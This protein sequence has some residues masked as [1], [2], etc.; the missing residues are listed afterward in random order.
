ME[1]QTSC[2]FL[3][4]GGFFTFFFSGTKNL[5]RK[6]RAEWEEIDEVNEDDQGHQNDSEAEAKDFTG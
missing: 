5:R 6:I 2:F 1:S 3:D 4:S